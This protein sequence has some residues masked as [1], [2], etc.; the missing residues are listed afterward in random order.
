[1]AMVTFDLE[2]QI[3]NLR[4]RKGDLDEHYWAEGLG[5]REASPGFGR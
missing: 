2:G 5:R 1:M 3:E 4:G